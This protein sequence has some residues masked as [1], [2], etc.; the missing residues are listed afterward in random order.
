MDP[1]RRRLFGQ[2]ALALLFGFARGGRATSGGGVSVDEA[3]ADVVPA[4]ADISELAPARAFAEKFITRPHFEFGNSVVFRLIQVQNG[5]K[6]LEKYRKNLDHYNR[7][8]EDSC[9]NYGAIRLNCAAKTLAQIFFIRGLDEAAKQPIYDLMRLRAETQDTQ[10][11]ATI[12]NTSGAL[13]RVADDIE[14]FRTLDK[15]AFR[16]FKSQSAHLKNIPRDLVDSENMAVKLSA[17]LDAREEEIYAHLEG[18][19]D[20]SYLSRKWVRDSVKDSAEKGVYAHASKGRVMALAIESL[21]GI[22]P[23]GFKSLMRKRVDGF[24]I[25]SEIFHGPMKMNPK[26]CLYKRDDLM[27]RKFVEEPDLYFHFTPQDYGD[28]RPGMTPFKISISDQPQAGL[29]ARAER[30]ITELEGVAAADYRNF[31]ARMAAMMA[32]KG[33]NADDP[34]YEVEGVEPPDGDEMCLRPAVFDADGLMNAATAAQRVLADLGI[35]AARDG[36]QQ[37]DDDGVVMQEI[38]LPEDVTVEDV[39][40]ALEHERMAVFEYEGRPVV[41]MRDTVEEAELVPVQDPGLS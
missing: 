31:R 23:D 10:Y 30:M 35:D 5:L 32:L 16:A 25:T 11:S 37:T 40:A 21:L 9:R 41:V 29:Q 19:F 27:N 33:P 6:D 12:S 4:G 36:W 18:T 38:I 24:I 14:A 7:T 1:F 3:L 8:K 20:Q 13:M 15:R 2:G 34:Y 26:D 17:W 22:T 39:N 28:L